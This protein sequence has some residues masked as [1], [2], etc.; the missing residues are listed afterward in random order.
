MAT[1]PR[2]PVPARTVAFEQKDILK[3]FA[4]RHSEGVCFALVV[5]W[6]FNGGNLSKMRPTRGKASRERINNLQDLMKDKHKAF[7][8]YG[9]SEIGEPL[10]TDS[11][12]E[13]A[14][15][16]CDNVGLFQV[17]LY[18]SGRGHAIGAITR[19]QKGQLFDPNNFEKTYDSNLALYRTSFKMVVQ[20]YQED[21]KLESLGAYRLSPLLIF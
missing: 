8:D 2:T 11:A 6:L 4:A 17:G 1:P 10:I 19:P 13:M 18:G 12:E 7:R 9:L 14:A 3:S 5:E 16:V 20:N 21:E 15:F